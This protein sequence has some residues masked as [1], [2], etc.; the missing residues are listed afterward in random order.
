MQAP[1]GSPARRRAGRA[2]GELVRIAGSG[3][4]ELTCARL[5][6]ARG[7]SIQL[8]PPPADT[9]SRPL[10]L[11]GPALELLDSLWGE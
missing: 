8:P 2:T 11:T 6:A 10:L 4:A 1:P 9:D 7:H 5:L 3:L